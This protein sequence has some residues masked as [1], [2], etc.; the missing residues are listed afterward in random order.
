MFLLYY[1]IVTLFVLGF[2]VRDFAPN[3]INV[4]QFSYLLLNWIK[5]WLWI[6]VSCFCCRR[7][8]ARN[9]IWGIHVC[10]CY[11]V[12]GYFWL[13]CL[14]RISVSNS[15][16][17]LLL[18]HFSVWRRL[19]LQWNSIYL[20]LIQIFRFAHIEWKFS[21]SESQWLFQ[22]KRQKSNATLLLPKEK[23]KKKSIEY[24]IRFVSL[25]IYKF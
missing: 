24:Y 21:F 11:P 19:Q 23:E 16:W 4:Q 2:S 7:L 6:I 1:Y 8:H 14:F 10:E 25:F 15:V 12:N 9:G 13:F 5:I 22:L 17:V 3:T 20:F 18:Y